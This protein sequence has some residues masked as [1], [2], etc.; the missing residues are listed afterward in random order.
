MSSHKYLVT[1]YSRAYHA[2][3]VIRSVYQHKNFV[4]V[5]IGNHIKQYVEVDEVQM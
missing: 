5:F 2:Y 3:S 1:V 4:P